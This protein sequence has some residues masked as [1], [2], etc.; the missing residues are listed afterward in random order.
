MC[1]K[2]KKE[3]THQNKYLYK[4]KQHFLLVEYWLTL[5]KKNKKKKIS[6]VLSVNNQ[7]QILL[8]NFLSM[9]LR[10]IWCTSTQSFIL[11]PLL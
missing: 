6:V 4:I 10:Q 3:N 9:I 1:L 5:Q 8:E 11:N 2:I 7:K